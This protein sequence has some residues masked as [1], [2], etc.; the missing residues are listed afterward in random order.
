MA[1]QHPLPF[2]PL[3]PPAAPRPYDRHM[4][5]V[6]DRILKS[7]MTWVQTAAHIHKLK[8][9]Q[10][11]PAGAAIAMLTERALNRMPPEPI[12][13]RIRQ[14]FDRLQQ[15]VVQLFHQTCGYRGQALTLMQQVQTNLLDNMDISPA[16]AINYQQRQNLNL[17]L[18]RLNETDALFRNNCM[19][20]FCGYDRIF[21]LLSLLA[22]Y[23][24]D[25]AWRETLISRQNLVR[26]AIRMISIL[27]ASIY[28]KRKA[29]ESVLN[30]NP[31]P[32]HQ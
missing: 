3:M 6:P 1:E 29:I 30:P 32:G 7:M 24:Y 26:A 17:S 23:W 20:Q 18:T 9:D 19:T 11:S 14:S 21:A 12:R 2:D 28:A 25:Q 4:T 10:P 27:R 13:A 22:W 31:N 16:N 8:L 5:D 15:D